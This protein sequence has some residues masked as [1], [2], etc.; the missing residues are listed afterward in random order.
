M[1]VTMSDCSVLFAKRKGGKAFRLK[2]LLESKLLAEFAT[3]S[4]LPL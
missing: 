2:T 3:L 1:L 4:Y